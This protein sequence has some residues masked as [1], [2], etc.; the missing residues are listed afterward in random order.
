MSLLDLLP[1][2][3]IW[4]EYL[5]YKTSRRLLNPREEARLR[6]YIA[7]GRYRSIAQGV[8]AGDYRFSTPVKHLVNKSS[9]GEKRVVYTFSEDETMLLK[10][11]SYL[12]YRYDGCF[13]PN[14]YA[15]RKNTGAKKA[16]SRFVRCEAIRSLY[17]YK[18]DIKNYF[19]SIPSGRLLPMLRQMLGD[20]RLYALFVDLLG[21]DRALYEGCLLHEQKGVMAGTPTSPFLANLYLRDLDRY[22]FENDV[23]YARYSDDLLLFGS[24]EAV[25]IHRETIRCFLE[26]AGL[27]I[28][29]QK[30]A[31]FAPHEPWDFLGFQFA[32][33]AVDLSP[34]AK[35]KIKA[36]IKRKA[37]KLRR[38]KLKKNADDQRVL[39][40]MNRIFNHKF[41]AVDSGRELSWA[42][43]FFPVL[44]TENGLREIDRYMQ[45]TQRYL[46]T[47]KYNKTNYQKVPYAL[48]QACGY[49]PL[50]AAYYDYRKSR[51]L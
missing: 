21:N 37:T 51:S 27:Q 48:L 6:D 35:R 42:R 34:V 11:L 41:F 50:V 13:S 43:W 3:E 47:G 33:G 12:L 19:N 38:W 24:E 7:N 8:C 44:T 1:R 2:D 36:K 20:D 10:L 9:G 4:V 39:C 17:G 40:A 28:N 22:F 29:P 5:D 25:R 32:D 46:V 16:L 15:F 45:E 31:F 23:L 49:R 14:C 18:A 26:E 30:E